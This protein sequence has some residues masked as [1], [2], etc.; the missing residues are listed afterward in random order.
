M[1][2]LTR[3][4]LETAWQDLPAKRRTLAELKVEVGTDWII[5]RNYQVE[6]WG[7]EILDYVARRPASDYYW[8]TELG[9]FF[10]RLGERARLLHVGDPDLRRRG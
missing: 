1:N 4:L 9:D 10:L 3:Q 5:W 8:D 6:Q 7:V 2:A